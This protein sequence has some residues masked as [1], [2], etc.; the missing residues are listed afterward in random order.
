MNAY[1]T[2]RVATRVTFRR[3]AHAVLNVF[4]CIARV[5][6][7]V[8]TLDGL[9]VIA[10]AALLGIGAVLAFIVEAVEGVVKSVGALIAMAALIAIPCG[11]VYVIF[12]FIV[13]Y[14]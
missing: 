6:L 13:K 5:L 10:L 9:K 8:F 1:T 3:I 11:I 4:R 2:L 7:N 12:H 14:W